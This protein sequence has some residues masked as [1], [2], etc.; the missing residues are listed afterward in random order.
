MS[1]PDPIKII[2]ADDHPIVREG[3]R[4]RLSTQPNMR[5]VAEAQNGKEAIKCVQDYAPAIVLM[6][7]NM[8]DMNG[9]EA[10]KVIVQNSPKTKVLVLSMHQD[11]EYVVEIMRSGARGYVLKNSPPAELIRAIELVHA[12]EAFFSPTISAVLLNE[13]SRAA[14]KPAVANLSDREKEVL[15]FVASGLSNK[16]IADK[17]GVGVRTI[18]THRERLMR[19]LDIHSVAGLTKFAI[20]EGVLRLQ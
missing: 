5:I 17:L 6:D 11:R 2:L 15:R 13:I 20:A 8:P 4:A 9:L 18:E 3:I 16:E 14:E 7:I 19:K 10:T 1:K 12:G